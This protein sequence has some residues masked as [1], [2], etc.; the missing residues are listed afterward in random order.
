VSVFRFVEQERATFA[1]TTMCRVLGVSPSG[2]WAWAK[3]PPSAR[4]RSYSVL[5]K[6]IRE[7]H[8]RSRGTYGA[9][10]VHAELREAGIRCS[11]KRV[12]RLMCEAGLAGVHRRR[13][14]VTTRRDPDAAPAPDLVGRDFR[15]AGPDRLW[16]AD[17]TA[18]PTWA[19][20]L[21]LAIVLD[22]WSR[23]LV[24]WAMDP[25]A[26][27]TLVTRALD[28]ALAARRPAL[29]LIHHSDHGSQ[30]TS[31]AF[32]R[33]MREAGIAP[34]MGR[35][36]DSYDNAMAESFFA[37]L[38]TELIDRTVWRTHAEARTAVFDWIETFYDRVRRHSALGYLAPAE[39]EARYR[40]GS[41]V[42]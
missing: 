14:V 6:A 15:A 36:G 25:S 2:Y 22:V 13:F 16:V 4:V 20:P 19:G 18:L 41:A 26:S 24:G 31:L 23:R 28:M 32:G 8:Q 3:R 37:S 29:G 38:E 21:Y 12:A 35:V 10:R 34:S 5:S 9:P 7:A 42:A 11:R 30:Y 39:Y 27:A 40:E 1:V 17:I 33:R